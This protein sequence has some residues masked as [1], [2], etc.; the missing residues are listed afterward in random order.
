MMIDDDVRHA[1][2]RKDVVGSGLME[3][4]RNDAFCLIENIFQFPIEKNSP[5]WYL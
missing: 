5:Q 3:I 4:D 1:V 2:W